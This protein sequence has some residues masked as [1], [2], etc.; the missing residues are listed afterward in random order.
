MS[1][2]VDLDARTIA[3]G[4]RAVV[5][6]AT[7]V[8]LINDAVERMNRIVIDATELVA[9]HLTRCFRD[10]LPL[11]LVD[12]NLYKDA[13]MLVTKGGK[14]SADAE[15]RRTRDGMSPLCPV[16]RKSLDQLMMLEAIGMA[17]RFN[18]NLHH[19]FRRRVAR[20]VR[21][22]R[23][24]EEPNDEADDEAK[25]RHK[26]H[27]LQVGADVCKKR[28]ETFDAPPE[29]HPM[30]TE[31]R[32]QLGTD[33]FETD[34]MDRNVKLCQ[35]EMTRA[36]HLMCAAFE[37]ADS[38]RHS[39]CPLRRRLVPRFVHFD[40]KALQSVLGLPVTDYQKCLHRDSARTRKVL[41][42]VKR[43]A[44]GVDADALRQRMLKHME[45]LVWLQ[46]EVR[47]WARAHKKQR[48]EERQATGLEQ[49][50]KEVWD[51]VLHLTRNAVKCRKG[52]TFAYGMRTDGAS[53]RLLFCRGDKPASGRKLKRKRDADKP[54]RPVDGASWP[55]R[56]LY[57]IDQ[58]K[59]LSRS[60]VQILGADPG[61]RELLVCVDADAPTYANE[62]RRRK[63]SV[64][65]TAAQRRYETQ[66]TRHAAEC[67]AETPEDLLARMRGMEDT[68]SRS[69]SFDVLSTYFTRRRGWLDEALSFFASQKLR[70]RRWQRFVGE[71]KSMTSF[72]R[73]IHGLQR[74]A[75][76]PL[77]LAYGS[78]ASVA[79]RPGAACNRGN[80]PCIGS[81]LCKKLS[82]H[83]CV[84]TTPEWRTSKTCSVC[85]SQC[86]PCR[87]VDAVRRIQ[88]VAAA[89]DDEKKLRAARRYSVRG[90]RRC[91]NNACL[92][93][94]N[95]D[96]NAAI[97]IQ[98]RCVAMLS[99]NDPSQDAVEEQL[100]CLELRLRCG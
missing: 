41:Q 71:Q 59:H 8:T 77:V 18:T 15:L 64:R 33:C 81:G 78:W 85:G 2:D 51:H 76:V 70:Q 80:P 21:L 19:H 49:S 94:L 23:Q 66:A 91:S 7:H 97:N 87:E 61:K 20:Y 63:S 40:T 22:R 95:R 60:H 13:M 68:D 37:R 52:D 47:T 45:R 48:R 90:L 96:H 31:L 65:Y 73:R 50:K 44:C 29:L 79:G 82:H 98:R 17:A 89:G 30:V 58:V 46:G 4:I 28:G 39:F 55:T 27:N 36:T 72:V 32:A 11:P 16:S 57:V 25:K 26:L 99:G 62:K 92:A 9:L 6:D 75:A 74:D 5:P 42:A 10:Q 54:S 69:T 3:T 84:V 24:D 100:D 38:K 56:G 14:P 43:E 1:G 88:K 67:R 53:V 83:F 93:H 86:G 35:R 34:F 12:A